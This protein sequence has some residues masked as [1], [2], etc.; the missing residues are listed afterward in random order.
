MGEG[1]G[2]RCLQT[3]EEHVQR[4]DRDTRDYKETS[5]AREEEQ[6]EYELNSYRQ[7]KYSGFYPENNGKL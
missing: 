4:Q 1:W 7:V 5:V 3:E 6:E 2:S